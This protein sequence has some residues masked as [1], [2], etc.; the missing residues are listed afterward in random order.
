[1]YNIGD[2]YE[3]FKGGKV[4]EYYERKIEEVDNPGFFKAFK[5]S[6]VLTTACWAVIIITVYKYLVN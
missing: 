3:E 1:M 2:S 6:V 5:W 4:V